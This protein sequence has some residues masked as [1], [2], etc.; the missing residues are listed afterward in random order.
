M[1]F[2][3]ANYYANVITNCIR[4]ATMLVFGLDFLMLAAWLA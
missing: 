2:K 3:D 1:N 4:I